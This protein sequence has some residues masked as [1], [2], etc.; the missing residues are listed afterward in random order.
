MSSLRGLKWWALLSGAVALVSGCIIFPPNI[1]FSSYM[2]PAGKGQ[3][4]E[5]YRT[6]EDGSI[7][8]A[9]EGLRLNV[10]CLTDAELNELLPEDSVRGKY[11]T[12]PYTYGDYVDGDV[13]HTPNRFTTFRVSVFN[14]T[15][16]K[17]ELDPLE[18]VLHTDQGE[19][20]HAYGIPSTS[21]HNSFERYYRGLRGQSGN[22][23]YRFEVRMG[24]VRSLNYAENQPVFKG[25][26]HNGLIA[27]DALDPEVKSARLVLKEFA[28]KFDEFGNVIEAINCQFDFD[29]RTEKWTLVEDALVSADSQNP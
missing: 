10:R 16:A 3:Q 6:E 2:E 14:Q 17:V 13:G 9:I 23:F 5:S 1:H 27:F 26:N 4:D 29:R 20:L 8:Y 24:H 21:P 12:N 28:L 18:A 22:E 11:S 19:V 25:E 7:S 15:F